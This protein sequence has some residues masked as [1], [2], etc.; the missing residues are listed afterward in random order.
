MR[1]DPT[2]RLGQERAGLGRPAVQEP[3]DHAVVGV[4]IDLVR[5]A[6][7]RYQQ[8]ERRSSVFAPV[9]TGVVDA[10]ELRS[11]RGQELGPDDRFVI[12]RVGPT[13][14]GIRGEYELPAEAADN[15]FELSAE[16][17][18]KAGVVSL[19][20]NLAEALD[21]MEQSELVADALGDHIFEW[22]L[23]NKRA[24]FDAYRAQV[25]PFELARYLAAW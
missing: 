12:H 14:A 1:I 5:R 20:Y 17:L 15:V 7:G 4:M 23:R 18:R 13:L 10:R 22:F 24:E 11:D 3:G 9:A 16:G 19:P 25:T 8:A 2:D 21:A 6:A